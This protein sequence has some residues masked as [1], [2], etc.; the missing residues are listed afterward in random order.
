MAKRLS[1]HVRILLFLTLLGLNAHLV[2]GGLTTRPTE[3]CI[4]CIS[5][6]GGLCIAC[7]EDVTW[8]GW[9]YCL[10]KQDTCS[11]DV[12]FECFYLE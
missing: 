2:I 8:S 3:A 11:C 4:R 7:A 9:N 12:A 10:A 1:I 6:T 5:V